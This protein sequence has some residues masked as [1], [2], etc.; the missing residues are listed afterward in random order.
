MKNT[1]VLISIAALLL[2]GCSGTSVHELKTGT[3]RGVIELQGQSLPFTFDVMHDSSNYTV[4]VINGDEKLALNEVTFFGDSVSI[5]LHIFDIQL[6]ARNYGD[7]LV[8]YYIKNYEKNYRIPFH[9]NAGENYRFSK[10]VDKPS[11]DF[12]GTYSVT[13][14]HDQKDTTVSVGIF[15]QQASHV[16]GTFLTP[17]GDYRYLEGDVVNNKLYLSTFDGNHAFLFTAD[18]S[19]DTLRGEYWSGK[20][21]H[22]YWTGVRNDKAALPNAES[23]TYLKDGYETF[24]ITFPDVTGKNVSLTDERFKNK[25]VIVQLFG[26][27]CPNCMDETKFLTSWYPANAERGVEIVGIAFERKADFAYASGRVIKMKEKLNVPYEFLIAPATDNKELASQALP[28]LNQV[29]AFPTTIFVGK[30][31]KVKHIHTGFSGPGTG[32]YYEQF[33]Q[34]FNEIVNELLAEEIASTP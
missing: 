24:D 9:A 16:E 14:I 18:K 34:R 22:E 12:T 1:L 5:V 13:F 8:G 15:K 21:W 11:V 20:T 32:M 25:V 4:N 28:M 6:R 29:I 26:T 30:D 10:T 33:K 23:L 3:W 17:T 27:W 7:S 19:G 31:G 2:A